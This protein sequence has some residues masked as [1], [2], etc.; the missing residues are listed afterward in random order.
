[1]RR[2]DLIVV[3][4][5][6]AGL[7]AASAWVERVPGARVC[8]VERERA[9]A[10]HATAR[11]AAVFLP[12]ERDEVSMRLA[13]RQRSLLDALFAGETLRWLRPTGALFAARDPSCVVPVRAAALAAGL[14]VEAVDR[15]ALLEAVPVLEGGDV[16]AG[17]AVPDA[18]VLEVGAIVDALVRRCRA[19][20]AALLTCAEASLVRVG[21]RVTGV[22][23]S[24]GTGI[25]A[26]LT[27]V[28][29]GAWSESLASSAGLGLP[30][31]PLRRHLALLAAPL[32]PETPV[33]WTLDDETYFRPESG[34]VLASP[35]DEVATEPVEPAV[36]EDALA[37]LGAR[38]ERLAPAL[39]DAPLRRAWACLRTFAPDRAAV[40]GIDPRVEG[41]AWMAGLG[42]Q[43]MTLGLAV[44]EVFAEAVLTGIPRSATSPEGMSGEAGS[45]ASV[46]SALAPARLLELS[47]RDA[48]AGESVEPPH[49]GPDVT[50]A[51]AGSTA[52][53][54]GRAHA[55]VVR[56]GAAGPPPGR[57]D[58]PASRQSEVTVR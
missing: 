37:E 57:A 21:D 7:A 54:R 25:A 12:V 24:D 58:E 29:G 9:L 11:N 49:G 19:A 23:L 41:L 18:G 30:L 36:D 15:G 32:P 51:A 46:A 39:A 13:L 4:G 47:R 17:L 31:T 3:G 28:A 27:L 1:V 14:R 45:A 50:R 40:A 2:A 26:P 8:L 56:A 22:R 38:L 6:I 48:S 34:G 43:G 55:E 35:C 5:G 10:T 52:A 20:G 33:L 16:V 42:G 44:A 53:T